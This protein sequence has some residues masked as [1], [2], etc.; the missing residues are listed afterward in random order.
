MQTRVIL[1]LF[2]LFKLSL[3][4]LT[5]RRNNQGLGSIPVDDELSKELDKIG[6]YMNNRLWTCGLLTSCKIDKMASSKEFLA[7]EQKSPFIAVKIYADLLSNCYENIESAK[8]ETYSL[9][10]KTNNVQCDSED[11][12]ELLRIVPEKYEKLNEEGILISPYQTVLAVAYAKLQ[13]KRKL[14][15]AEKIFIENTKDKKYFRCF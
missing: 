9:H 5:I 13:E 4:V 10:S 14:I 1:I 15:E 7:L 3:A 2:A 11:F 6:Q 8:A 12:S